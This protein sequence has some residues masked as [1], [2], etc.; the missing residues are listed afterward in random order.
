[1][2]TTKASPAGAGQYGTSVQVS[3]LAAAKVLDEI[4]RKPNP[5]R[6]VTPAKVRNKRKMIGAGA[7]K[8]SETVIAC[9]RDNGRLE[10]YITALRTLMY[11]GETAAP[12]ADV[13]RRVTATERSIAQPIEELFANRASSQDYAALARGAHELDEESE[14]LSD[15]AA[16]QQYAPQIRRSA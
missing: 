1:M 16:R 15:L 7:C 10:E 9:L 6:G 3:D 13:A 12:I 5:R 2:P 14:L 8:P 11:P 4:L